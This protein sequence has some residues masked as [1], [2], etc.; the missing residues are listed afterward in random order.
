MFQ[1]VLLPSR[2]KHRRAFSSCSKGLGE[3]EAKAEAEKGEFEW[4]MTSANSGGGGGGGGGVM[5]GDGVVCHSF[6]LEVFQ[7]R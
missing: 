2:S 3:R 1:A 4:R 5:C 6:F 7:G